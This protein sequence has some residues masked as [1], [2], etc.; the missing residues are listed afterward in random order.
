MS[1]QPVKRS[2]AAT[3]AANAATPATAPTAKARTDRSANPSAAAYD[4]ES[5]KV[6]RG[7]DADS[8]D[9]QGGFGVSVALR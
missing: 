3:A 7:L 8:V 4:A 9:W 6:L 1:E 5:I 2:A